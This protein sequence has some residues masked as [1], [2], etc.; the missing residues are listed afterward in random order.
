M[1]ARLPTVLVVL[2]IVATAGAFG[3][4]ELLKLE[5]NPVSGPR[6]DKEFSPVCRCASGL[7]RI[8]FRLRRADHVI[9]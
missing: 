5:T 8:S 4:T 1:T 2:L 9:Q 3:R 7:A 6:V